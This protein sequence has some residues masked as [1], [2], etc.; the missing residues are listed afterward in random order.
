MDGVEVRSEDMSFTLLN[1]EQTLGLRVFMPGYTEE[2][3]M[4][5]IA[6]LFLDEALGEFDV[7]TKLALIKLLPTD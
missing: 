7:E 4:R 1:K 2:G 6:Y 5:G 3:P